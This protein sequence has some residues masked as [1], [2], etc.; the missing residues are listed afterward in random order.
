[1]S[2]LPEGWAKTTLGNIISLKYGKSLPKAIR[3]AGPFSV[4]GSNGPVGTH[5]EPLISGPAIIVGRKGSIGELH[6]SEEPC[7]PIDTTYFVDEFFDQSPHFLLFLLKTLGLT[8]LNRAS[9]IPGLNRDDVYALP[10]LLPPLDEQRRIVAKLDSLFARTRR[11]RKELSHIPRLI[12]SYKNSILEAAFRGYLT[13]DWRGSE[14]LADWERKE[15]SQV[16]EE[17]LANGRSVPDGDGFPVLRLTALRNQILDLSARKLGNWDRSKADRYIVKSGD[18]L[19]SR[20]NGS[21]D[22]LARGSYI[23][24]VEEEVAF[25]DTMIRIRP[26]RAIIYTPFLY[27]QWFYKGVRSQIISMAKTTAGIYKVSQYDLSKILLVVPPLD[28]Q[29]EIVCRIEKTLDWLRVVGDEQ[30]KARHLLDR[31][32]E[33]NLSK[34]FRGELVPQ[35]PNEEP[36]SV[37]LERICAARAQ[38]PKNTREGRGKTANVGAAA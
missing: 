22:L 12:E 14:Y 35:D 33:A 23:E 16:L 9:A 6:L 7:Y 19:V 28:E 3:V 17:R 27:H 15:L 21:L 8:E 25:P 34:A 10:V 18:F 20:G 26:K 13:K 32:D 5:T 29:K 1:M 4:Y 31:L 38:Q 30:Q 2:E 37:L 24:K 11:A 36:A